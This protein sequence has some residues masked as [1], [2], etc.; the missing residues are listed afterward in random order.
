MFLYLV[1]H[2]IDAASTS[3]KCI[4]G[5]FKQISHFLFIF[6]NRVFLIVL[7]KETYCC[8][9]IF[10]LGIRYLFLQFRSSTDESV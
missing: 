9:S 8:W 6:L 10:S 1:F 7:S 5:S 2:F 3:V 4:K